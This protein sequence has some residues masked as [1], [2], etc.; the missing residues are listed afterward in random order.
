MK[1]EK[2]A[3]IDDQIHRKIRAKTAHKPGE[4]NHKNRKTEKLQ[5]PPIR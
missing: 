2:T 3:D 5:C 4:I 1:N